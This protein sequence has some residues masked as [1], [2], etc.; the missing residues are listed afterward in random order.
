MQYKCVATCECMCHIF[1]P[2][3]PTSRMLDN[4]AKTITGI[5][6]LA[7]NIHTHTYTLHH[8][9]H[10]VPLR[11]NCWVEIIH[12]V[13]IFLS[14]PT[15][16]RTLHLAHCS[17]T[18]TGPNECLCMHAYCVQSMSEGGATEEARVEGRKEGQWSRVLDVP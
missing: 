17:Q 12:P 10:S 13:T 2:S 15:N 11:S 8:Q 1:L 9:N 7:R 16:A 4:V 3:W 6:K 5:N 14:A 18:I